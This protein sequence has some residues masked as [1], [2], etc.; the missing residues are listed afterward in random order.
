MAFLFTNNLNGVRKVISK[1]STKTSLCP[2]FMVWKIHP[3]EGL[4]AS[5]LAISTELEK[6]EQN[7]FS[8]KHT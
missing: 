7:H 1:I 3:P 5:D 6:F 2:Q 4:Q 8:Q